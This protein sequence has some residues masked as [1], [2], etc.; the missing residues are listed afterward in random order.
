MLDTPP[1]AA[2]A[3]IRKWNPGAA[4]LACP[5]PERAGD[6]ALA[7]LLR[8]ADALDRAAERD[9]A[10]LVEALCDR[11]AAARLRAALAQ[12]GAARRLRLVES[13]GEPGPAARS[14]ASGG[15][16]AR[17]RGSQQRAGAPRHGGRH[18]AR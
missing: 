18:A 5:G 8:F 6:H 2:S 9:A 12:A 4:A 7:A 15:G 13:L 11:D 1:A 17:A 10:E 14:P 16:P 3:W